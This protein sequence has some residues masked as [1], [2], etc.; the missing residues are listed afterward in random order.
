MNTVEPVPTAGRR[1]W[2]LGAGAAALVAGAGVAWWQGGRARPADAGA[3]DA[4]WRLDTP[5]PD[6][7]TLA[8]SAFRGRPLLVN[9]WA[10][11]CPPCVEELPLVDAFFRQHAPN[12]WQVV[13]LALDKPAAVQAFLGK[14]PVTFPVGI[15]GMSGMDLLRTLGN[16]GGGLPFTVVLDA[17]GAVQARKMGQITLTD[18]QGWASGASRS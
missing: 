4:L 17:A 16:S 10:T 6:G 8:M 15:L 18:L 7:A 9:F 12:G 1:A 5:R 14:A 2:M 11:W 3:V 13:G